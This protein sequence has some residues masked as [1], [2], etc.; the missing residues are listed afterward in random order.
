MRE[1]VLQKYEGDDSGGTAWCVDVPLNETGGVGNGG[2]FNAAGIAGANAAGQGGVI[3]TGGYPYSTGSSGN[4]CQSSSGGSGSDPWL[5]NDVEVARTW[6]PSKGCPSLEQ[7]R[8]IARLDRGYE[9]AGSF[10]GMKEGK[11]CYTSPGFCAGG[12]PFLVDGRARTA[13]LRSSRSAPRDTVHAALAEEWLNDALTEHA[14]IAAFARLSLQLMALGAP[15][16]LVRESQLSSL[17]EAR[18]AEICFTQAARHGI[19]AE[20]GPLDVPHAFDDTSLETVLLLN[21]L[22]GC[23]GETLASARVFAQARS[24]ASP[25]LREALTSIAQ[26]EERHAVLAWRILRWGL[27]VAPERTGRAARA[28]VESFLAAKGVTTEAAAPRPWEAAPEWTAEGRLAAGEGEQI[29]HATLRDVV[30]P[31]IA[32]LLDTRPRDTDAAALTATTA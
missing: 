10:D 4:V 2:A 9:D 7:Y 22:E 23:I 32:E 14:S 30:L 17:D 12:R 21:V 18:H 6:D 15:L 26:D 3:A 28:A 29:D 20:P 1:R 27:D 19:H 24:A 25:E 13:E 11:C 8:A 31:L 16:E 5:Q